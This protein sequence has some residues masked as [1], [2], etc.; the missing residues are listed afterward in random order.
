[1]MG[2]LLRILRISRLSS[3]TGRA[4]GAPGTSPIGEAAPVKLGTIWGGFWGAL[5][6]V[7]R[8]ADEHQ[9]PPSSEPARGARSLFRP[10]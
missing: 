9:H 6:G 10:E 7:D 3:T 4:K 2:G 8:A 1:M 5:W